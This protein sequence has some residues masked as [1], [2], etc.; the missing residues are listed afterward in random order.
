M[1]RKVYVE[2]VSV[3]ILEMSDKAIIFLLN[4]A[5]SLTSNFLNYHKHVRKYKQMKPVKIFRT[6]ETCKKI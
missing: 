6:F 5:Q 2:F 3:K 4:Y 1:R